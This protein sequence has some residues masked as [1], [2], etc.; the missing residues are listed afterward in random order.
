MFPADTEVLFVDADS[1]ACSDDGPIVEHLESVEVE[2][3][4]YAIA[5][6]S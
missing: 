4:T 3:F 1:V 2:D 5:T 6:K